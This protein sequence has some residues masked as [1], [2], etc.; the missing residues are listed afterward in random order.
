MSDFQQMADEYQQAVEGAATDLMAQLSAPE[1][2]DLAALVRDFDAGSFMSDFDNSLSPDQLA[3]WKAAC[4]ACDDGWTG[5]AYGLICRFVQY[6][7]SQ[8]ADKNLR[9]YPPGGQHE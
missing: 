1:N 5:V 3:R 4:A 2:A 7:L 9:H 8:V 6:R